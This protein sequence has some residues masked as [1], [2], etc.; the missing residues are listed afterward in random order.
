MD[1]HII[2]IYSSSSSLASKFKERIINCQK[3]LEEELGVKVILGNLIFKN[4]N[5]YTTGT[6][7]ERANEFNTLIQ[8]C[9][10]LMPSIGG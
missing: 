1:F 2:G 10:I 7:I 9:E 8:K 6:N 4:V 5:N 3:R